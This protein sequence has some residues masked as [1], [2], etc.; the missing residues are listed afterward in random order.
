MR[1]LRAIEHV[2]RGV[3]LLIVLATLMVAITAATILLVAAADVR[4]QRDFAHDELIAQNLLAAVETPIQAWLEN[5][6]AQVVLPPDVRMPAVNV[7]HDCW[8]IEI[9]SPSGES[10]HANNE[11]EVE[12]IITAFDQYGMVP[13][14][15]ARSGAPLRLSLPAEVLLR[16]DALQL[17]PESDPTPLGL[18]LFN[19]ALTDDDADVPV[20]TRAT[21][22]DSVVFGD[23][24]ADDFS[25]RMPGATA[26]I[27]LGGLVATHNHDPVRININTA[28]LLLVGAALRAA[29]TSG[30]EQIV[31]SRRKGKSASAGRER[32]KRETSDSIE[33]R[34]IPQI[35]TASDRW[36]FRI[37]LHVWGVGGAGGLWHSWWATYAPAPDDPDTPQRETWGCV[38]R[39]PITQ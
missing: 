32:A 30:L 10:D 12:I 22:A 4:V 31:E 18:D 21:S 11:I 19:S 27:A 13:M 23:A 14:R 37:D 2:R 28:P 26:D 7:L 20:F 5:E 1:T 16:L 25:R 33:A 36:S 34:S 9:T 39:L 29:G 38:Q 24:P 6:S 3:A 15:L 35:V 8:K 17:P